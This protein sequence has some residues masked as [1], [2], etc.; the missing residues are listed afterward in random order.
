MNRARLVHISFAVAQ[1]NPPIEELKKV[2]DG[3]M[4]WVRYAPHAWIVLTGLPIHTWRDRIRNCPGIQPQDS[5]FLC[6]FDPSQADGYQDSM[7][8]EWLKKQRPRLYT[9]TQS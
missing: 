9:Y 5:F 1:G 7:I 3:A 4:D 2:F 6:E 8:W